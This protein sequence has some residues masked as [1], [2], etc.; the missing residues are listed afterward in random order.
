[1][2]NQKIKEAAKEKGVRFWRIAERL[3]IADA[4]FSRKLRHQFSA[5]DEAR[6]LA[7][8]DQLAKEGEE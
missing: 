4:T 6:I 7:I 2:T 3:G 8:I 5:T 1:M